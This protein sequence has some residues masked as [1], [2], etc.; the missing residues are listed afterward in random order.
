[1]VTQV[2]SPTSL[3]VELAAFQ[4]AARRWSGLTRKSAEAVLRTSAKM[5]LSNPRQGSGL[6]QITPPSSKGKFGTAGRRQGERAVDRDLGVIFVPV[7]I[8][9]V[10]APPPDP[11]PIHRRHFIAFKRPGRRM[12]RD[13]SQPYYVDQRQYNALRRVLL[14]RIGKL[15]SG[16]VAAARQLNAAVPAWIARHGSSRGTIRMSFSMRNSF[17]EMTCFAPVH[18]PWEEMQRR[19]PYALRYATNNLERQIEYRLKRDAGA[20]GFGVR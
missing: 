8:K 12:R 17:V 16:W 14:S 6:L 5:T 10:G 1:M 19:V 13:R 3:T 7:R 4:A 15:A 18:A 11:A 9:G 2:S 20:A